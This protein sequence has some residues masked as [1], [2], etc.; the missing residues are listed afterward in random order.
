MGLRIF[1]SKIVGGAPLLGSELLP[2]ILDVAVKEVGHLLNGRA[3]SEAI[4]K[5]GEIDRG[6]R[7]SMLSIHGSPH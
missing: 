5:F 1:S 6:P 4:S 2:D 7:P 3:K